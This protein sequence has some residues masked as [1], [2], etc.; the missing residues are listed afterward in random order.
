M[1]RSKHV[2][3]LAAALLAF[4]A[5]GCTTTGDEE[6]PVWE[7]VW[8]DEFD[9]QAG[10]PPGE[11]WAFDIGGGGWGNDELQ[12][13]TDR[14]EN[15]GLTGEG[16]LRI[17]AIREDFDGDPWTSA[18]INTQGLQEFEY[19]RF[20]ARI[21]VPIERGV[22]PAFWMLGAD[23]DKNL[24]P[25]AGEID[26]MSVFGLESVNHI[27]HGPGYSGNQ[28]IELPHLDGSAAV[29]GFDADFHVFELLWDPG[30]VVF[31]VDGE[32]SQVA[33]PADIPEG[34]AWVFDHEFFLLL[35]MAVGGNPVQDPDDS[36]PGSNDLLVDYVRV[37]E[38]IEP[39]LDL[40]VPIEE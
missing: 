2:A 9:G 7:L 31:L 34:A 40:T 28:R 30:H 39:V 4:G 6:G 35:S 15:I 3:S 37:Y 33:T 36:T 10:D 17:T 12:N 23:I 13:Y 16:E 11:D 20:E 21:Q 29:E 19:G 38:R 25:L 32:V 27:L 14:V 24:F 5:V 1:S 18:R 22:W 26:I 8:E